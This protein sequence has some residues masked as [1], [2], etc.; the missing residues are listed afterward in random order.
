MRLHVCISKLTIIGSDNGLSSARCQVIIWTYAGTLLIGPLGTNLS[1]IL[2]KIYIFI[3]QNALENA[4]LKIA[5]ILCRP[6]CVNT[7]KT[8][9]HDI[10]LNTTVTNMGFRCDNELTM[11]FLYPTF[12]Y[13]ISL[14]IVNA[15]CLIRINSIVLTQFCS[16]SLDVHPDRTHQSDMICYWHERV[17]E[18]IDLTA[19]L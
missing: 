12:I 6:Q 19:L 13:E 8:T 7:V 1:E 10:T 5:A 4:V 16:V 9:S 18:C 17:Q 2:I 15:L 14:S 11:N 3:Q